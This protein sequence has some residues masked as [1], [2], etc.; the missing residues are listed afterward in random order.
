MSAVAQ[1]RR[2]ISSALALGE[3]EVT[4]R[5]SRVAS[6]AADTQEALD[7]IAALVLRVEGIRTV[8][9]EHREELRQLAPGPF[10]WG[11]KTAAV[12]EGSA[13]ADVV[14]R[15][16]HWGTLRIGFQLRLIP[17]ES[18]LRFARFVG[19]QMA[20]VIDRLGRVRERAT[21]LETVEQLRNI[22]ASRKAIERAKGILA[23]RQ[24]IT[25]A[26]AGAVLRKYSSESGNDLRRVAEAV[27][28][29]EQAGQ[30]DACFRFA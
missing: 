28:L 13:T 14:S 29:S 27:I 7:E 30:D 16:S 25:P 4:H 1:P 24:K 2:I 3:L 8:Q 5:I 23:D 17:V 22:L 21:L 20:A 19:E 11:H 6:Q 18:P 15:G 9:V 10:V 12:N 26:E